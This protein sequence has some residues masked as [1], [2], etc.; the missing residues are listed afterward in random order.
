MYL[1]P[2][3]AV[4][5]NLVASPLWAGSSLGETEVLLHVGS[6]R[7]NGNSSEVHIDEMR[8][9]YGHRFRA[10]LEFLTQ[11]SHYRPRGRRDGIAVDTHGLGLAFALRWH[12][13]EVGRYG[14]YADWGFGAMG[15]R[16]PFPPVGTHFNGTPHFGFGLRA[17]LTEQY[18]T[19]VELRQRHMSNGQ[20]I[21]ST[22]P[23][24]DGLGGFLSLSR[25]LGHRAPFPAVQATQSFGGMASRYRVEF[26]YEDVNESN[27]PGGRIAYDTALLAETGLRLLVSYTAA[28]LADELIWTAEWHLYRETPGG[29]HGLGYARQRYNVFASDFFTLQIEKILDDISV[30]QFVGG[31]ERRSHDMDR[32]YGGA[33]VTI[34]PLTSL[35]LR[36]GIAFEQHRGQVFSSLEKLND[37]G[38]NFGVEWSPRPLAALGLSITL[39]ERI[40]ADARSIGLRWRPGAGIGLGE[41]QRRGDLLPLR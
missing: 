40:I 5:L 17:E 33:M 24:F 34:A 22:N 35:S 36:S 31:Y 19:L 14:L 27:S 3:I 4:L 6:I 12:F 15:A 16:A 18:G 8:L 2:I 20:G 29:R 23:S 9:D 21:V 10:H 32:L 41:R 13:L 39:D 7:G 11:A 28:E 1:R 37:G 25:R 30:L 26:I 38:F